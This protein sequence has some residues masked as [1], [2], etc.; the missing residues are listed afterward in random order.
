MQT[1]SIEK[2]KTERKKLYLK[3]KKKKHAYICK[4][5]LALPCCLNWVQVNIDA[6][7]VQR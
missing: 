7:L 5:S 4:L 3:K 2:N 1:V 6:S